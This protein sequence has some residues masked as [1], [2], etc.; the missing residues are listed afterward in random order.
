MHTL[1][2][3]TPFEYTDA[4]RALLGV[5][6]EELADDVIMS[7]SIVGQ[8]EL[9]LY[10]IV[11]NI[12]TRIEDPNITDMEAN[13]LM[14]AF[15]NLIAYFAY[16]PLK[17]LLLS[18]ETDNKTMATRFKDALTRDPNEFKAAA[19][20]TLTQLGIAPVSRPGLFSVVKPGTDEITGKANA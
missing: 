17:V 10:S 5:T 9:E 12:K 14:I 4:V 15:I 7:I 18:S 20:K 16:G 6:T 2:F 13:Q 19:L 1:S 11:P 3:D 8:A